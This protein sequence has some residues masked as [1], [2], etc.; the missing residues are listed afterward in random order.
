MNVIPEPYLSILQLIA[1]IIFIY[2]LVRNWNK[3]EESDR[4][5]AIKTLQMVV[6]VFTMVFS[7]V[8]LIVFYNNP[9]AREKSFEIMKWITLALLLIGGLY[10]EFKYGH[11]QKIH[12]Q[13][14]E[15]PNDSL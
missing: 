10:I 4:D 9:T 7:C 2:W 15:N 5:V 1:F 8:M 12:T 13:H 6:F 11:N 3:I 14:Q